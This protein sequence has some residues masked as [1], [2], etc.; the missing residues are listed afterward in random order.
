MDSVTRALETED[1]EAHGKWVRS[2]ARGLLTEGEAEDLAQDVWVATLEKPPRRKT[3]GGLRP[4]LSKVARNLAGQTLR[5]RLRQAEAKAS[6]DPRTAPDPASLLM[7]A[8][9]HRKVVEALLGLEEPFRTALLLRFFE[10]MNSAQIARHLNLHPTTVRHRIQR[11]LEILRWK[12]RESDGDFRQ[13]CLAVLGIPA[14]LW[15]GPGGPSS[16]PWTALSAG[17][18]AAGL[19]LAGAVVVGVAPLFRA[20]GPSPEAPAV[21]LPAVPALS[22]AAVPETMA[23][24]PETGLPGRSLL[25]VALPALRVPSPAPQAGTTVRVRFRTPDGRS[26]IQA[27]EPRLYVSR[28]HL[29]VV[30]T[31]DPISGPLTLSFY[32]SADGEPD[33]G[34]WIGGGSRSTAPL[35]AGFD[36][37]VTLP[38]SGPVHLTATYGNLILDSQVYDPA[39][40][41]GTVTF[42]LSPEALFLRLQSVTLHFVDAVS[43]DPISSGKVDLWTAEGE[44]GRKALSADGSVT[45]AD[46]DPGYRKVMGFFPGYEAIDMPVRIPRGGDVDLGTIALL[47]RTT[48][49]GR[50]IASDGQALDLHRTFLYYRDPRLIGDGCFSDSGGLTAKVEPDG[51]F[52]CWGAGTGSQVLQ[53]GGFDFASEAML[54]DTSQG[55][56]TDLVLQLHTGTPVTLQPRLGPTQTRRIVIRDQATGLPV[57]SLSLEGMRD[58]NLQLVPGIYK[59]ECAADDGVHWVKSLDVRGDPVGFSVDP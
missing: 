41:D 47:P 6:Q 58:L 36:G 16:R 4:W 32:A 25:A 17:K 52:L 31:P 23:L 33:N 12:L 39:Q 45:F 27:L 15:V 24:P 37:E 19:V 51:T 56:V 48:I 57:W 14:G 29:G 46:I 50:L 35:P 22:R 49:S 18:L 30:V 34:A 9:A 26:F 13:T 42:V 53:F 1:V 7:R 43:G 11:G 8:E 28:D 5:R 55:P 10:P 2:L 38:G 3:A 59:V 20:A 54:V 21:T 40:G 44:T